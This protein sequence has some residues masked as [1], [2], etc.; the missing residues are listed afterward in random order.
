MQ[1]AMLTKKVGQLMVCG[2]ADKTPSEEIVRLIRN[3]HVG[4]IILFSRNI[5][6]AQEVLALTN[7]LQQ[8]AKEAGHERPLLICVDQENGIVRRLG[9]G[10]TYFPGSMLIGATGNS[11][12]AYD[13]G[14][15][16]GKEL[17]ALGINWNLAPVVDINNNPG[18][19]VIGVRSFGE[20]TDLVSAYA[21][22]N[23]RGMHQAGVITT[24]KHFPG[25]GD[26]DSDSHLKLP[27]I[28][29]H[30]ERLEAVELKPFRA[31][32]KAGADTVMSAH[33]FFPALVK[34]EKPA[35]L[36]TEVMTGL[37]RDQLGF[38]GV[39]TTDCMEMNAIADTYG[40]VEGATRAIKAGV[41]IIMISH[42]HILQE[43]AIKKLVEQVEAGDIQ[44]EKIETSYMRVQQL[45][46]KYLDWDH[47]ENNRQL[48]AVVGCE[49]HQAL[50][51][52]SFQRGHYHL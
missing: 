6:T 36:A 50:A 31:C 5:G 47:I 48:D 35:T 49:E 40:T 28:P 14:L 23:I 52:K 46:E 34:E 9:E 22:E 8:I 44:L 20:D 26:T 32:M 37:L 30:M 17:K 11:K 1:T 27:V 41:D 4:G 16:T 19:P 25:H 2:F 33:V 24:L 12:N 13:I 43:K 15:A 3:Y 42:T 39:V 21:I 29:H 45:K 51:E 38:Q 18:N 10:T 7:A